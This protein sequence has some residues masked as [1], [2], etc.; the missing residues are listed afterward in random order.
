MGVGG[1][2]HLGLSGCIGWFFGLLA[3]CHRKLQQ[4][5]RHKHRVVKTD[6]GRGEEQRHIL[7][8]ISFSAR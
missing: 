2:G 4:L 1:Y 6:E 3:L 5:A 8:A 7:N